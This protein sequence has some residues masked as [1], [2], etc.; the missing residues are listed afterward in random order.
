MS[1]DITL[2]QWLVGLGFS[3]QSWWKKYEMKIIKQK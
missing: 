1:L 2:S 3:A